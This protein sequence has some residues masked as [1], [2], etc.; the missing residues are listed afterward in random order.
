VASGRNELAGGLV[1]L[2]A[3]EA[4]DLEVFSTF[5]RDSQGARQ[6]GQTELPVSPESRR[7]WHEEDAAKRPDGDTRQL[8]IETLGGQLVGS[9]SVDHADRRNKVFSYGIGLGS[10]HRGKGYGTEALVLLLRFYFGELGYQKCDTGVYAFNEGSLR[11]HERLGFVV[12]GRRRRSIF[13]QGEYH[14]VVLIGITREEFEARHPLVA[15]PAG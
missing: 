12:E 5:D 1:R 13:T 7:R 15:P 14:D 6:W 8:A 10:E 9:V 4:E 2:R 3:V 11:F